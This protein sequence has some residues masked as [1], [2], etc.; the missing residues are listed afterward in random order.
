MSSLLALLLAFRLTNAL[1]FRASWC[2]TALEVALAPVSLL[3]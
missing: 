3:C 2:S 1:A